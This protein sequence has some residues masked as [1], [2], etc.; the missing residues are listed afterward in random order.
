MIYVVKGPAK[1][2]KTWLAN[3]LRNKALSTKAG[4]LLVDEDQT[5]APA[6]LLAKLLI[7]MS[8]DDAFGDKRVPVASLPWKKDP[9]IVFVGKKEKLLADFEVLVPGFTKKF[10]PVLEVKV[11]QVK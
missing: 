8:A 6:D 10:G 3:A 4:A 2:G 7:D 1:S 11:A 5:G 9:T